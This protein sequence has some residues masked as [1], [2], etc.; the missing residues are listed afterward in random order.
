MDLGKGAAGSTTEAPVLRL[1]IVLGR[2]QAVA[3]S[4]SYTTKS[5]QGISF[6]FPKAPLAPGG[7]HGGPKVLLR[8][9]RGAEPTAISRVLSVQ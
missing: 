3:Y 2:K 5:G 7:P 8:P 6:A 4:T 9:G 1:Q